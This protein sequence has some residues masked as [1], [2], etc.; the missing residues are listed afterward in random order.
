MN[1]FRLRNIYPA[2]LAALAMTAGPGVAQTT[3]QADPPPATSKPAP[4]PRTERTPP[5]KADPAPPP[6]NDPV[7]TGTVPAPRDDQ[8]ERNRDPRPA[9][10]GTVRE[11][12][13]SQGIRVRDMLG[14]GVAVQDGQAVGSVYDMIVNNQ[15]MIEYVL[16]N[17][18]G[19]LV[20]VPWRAVQIDVTPGAG[21]DAVDPAARPRNRLSIRGMT[22][23][24]Y[25]TAPRFTAEAYPDFYSPDYN[26]EAT[27]FYNLRP[28]DPDYLDRGVLSG[29]T[30]DGPPAGIR[31][32]T[33]P[34]DRDDNLPPARD[35]IPPAPAPAPAERP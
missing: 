34:G 32:P 35:P 6:K 12:A 29:A 18:G 15:G 13:R 4:E 17:E 19:K 27:Q 21:A 26:T 28:S 33:L 11:T 8:P 1:R 14:V 9:T 30:R 3:A 10:N 16:V 31:P 5:P 7:R 22:A 2:G 23:D 25:R 24:R 20:S